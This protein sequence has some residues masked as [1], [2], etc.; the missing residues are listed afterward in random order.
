MDNALRVLPVS[1]L[2]A[3][4]AFGCDR[5]GLHSTGSG[6]S[7]PGAEGPGGQVSGQSG[8]ISGSGGLPVGGMTNTGQ[9]PSGGTSG[10]DTVA[11]GGG[12]GLA[13]DG[14]SASR[15]PYVGD[16]ATC[17]DYPDVGYR[18]FPNDELSLAGD[19]PWPTCPLDCAQAMAA[20]ASFF[21][22]DQALPS[23]P[24]GDEGATCDSPLM[25]EWCPPC[26]G[27]VTGGPSNGYTC[28][29]RSNQWQCA[30]KGLGTAVCSSPACIV[31]AP[32]YQY[33][34]VVWSTSQVCACGVCRDLCTSDA[35]CAS[36]KCN[37]NQVCNAPADCPGPD[38]C[39]VSCTGLCAQ[40]TFDGGPISG[41]GGQD[42]SYDNVGTVLHDGGLVSDGMSQTSTDGTVGTD[43]SSTWIDRTAGTAAASLGW[44]AV[45]SDSTGTHLVA[46]TNLGSI[47]MAGDIWTS[48]DSGVTWTNMTKGTQASGQSWEAVASDS[49]GT[50][51][52]AMTGRAGTSPGG[53]VWTSAD[54]GT[55]W[56][57]RLTVTFTSDANVG[58]TVVSDSTGTHLVVAA[59]DI[60]TTPDSGTT[61][62]DQ[63]AG[64][65]AAAQNWVDMASDSTGTHLVAI[66]ADSDIW[67]STNSGATWTDQTKGTPA[68][69]LDWQSVA[70]D[71]TGTHLV[72]VCQVSATSGG[73]LYSG[74]IWIS[75][76]SGTT[77]T[78]RTEG[79]AASGQ[80]W[81]AVA[82]DSTGTHLVAASSHGNANDIWTSADSGMTWT[83]E[84]VGTA[85]SGQQWGAVASN[86]TGTH[87]VAVSTDPPGV[88][89]CCQ[90]D[91]WTN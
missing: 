50:H 59:G 51:L 45:A 88:G 87:L 42:A 33:C 57:K 7:S 30:I 22:L 82:S 2:V 73:V 10:G 40:V 53:D 76:D 13:G 35:D 85:A 21:P 14:P 81:G 41:M 5:T 61:W 12:G 4:L 15:H 78:N 62:T 52:A 60:W 38:E 9:G 28:T 18:V 32:V 54:A 55:T 90:G 17:V 39:M 70:S 71:S 49:T 6:G 68:S 56:N 74:D 83:N 29:C 46:T 67:I 72:A 64:T 86:A 79:T 66:T 48:V 43:S 1:T 20:P 91:I 24:C 11:G 58:P 89:F 16:G 8:G 34:S 44:T 31:S 84:T 47:T 75:A 26:T 77:W 3:L 65:S 63:T 23:G 80:E 19:P 69:G 37:P 27:G 36:G 25:A